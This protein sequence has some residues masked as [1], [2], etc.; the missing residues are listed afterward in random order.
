MTP[1]A[2][3]QDAAVKTG[4]AAVRDELKPLPSQYRTEPV[5]LPTVCMRMT[6]HGAER[7]LL[8]RLE[9]AIMKSGSPSMKVGGKHA[10]DP[11]SHRPEIGCDIG[12]AGDLREPQIL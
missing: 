4:L 11:W 8:A 7:K 6:L 12:G 1:G 10:G 3:P 9:A 2:R 5:A